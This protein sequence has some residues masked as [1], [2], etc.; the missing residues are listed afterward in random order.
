MAKRANTLWAFNQ[1]SLSKLGNYLHAAEFANQ[2]RTDN[3]VS[4]PV[5]PGA[6]DSELWREQNSLTQTF[7]RLTLLHPTVYGAYTCIYAAFSPEITLEKSGT[8]G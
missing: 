2:Y 4:V 6:L 7:L 5:N 1:Y 8:Y 3:V